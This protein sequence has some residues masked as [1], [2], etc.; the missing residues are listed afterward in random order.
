MRPSEW[1]PGPLGSIIKPRWSDVATWRPTTRQRP[2]C[3][4]ESCATVRLLSFVCKRQAPSRMAAE[5]TLLL[6]VAV[7]SAQCPLVLPEAWCCA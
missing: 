3:A 5:A 7:A 4:L 6:Y 2:A 1:C